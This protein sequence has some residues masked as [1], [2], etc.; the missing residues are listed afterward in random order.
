MFQQHQTLSRTV[1]INFGF[2][3]KGAIIKI[4]AISG[5]ATCDA[6]GLT[7]VVLRAHASI[8]Q[9]TGFWVF[10]LVHQGGE[11]ARVAEAMRN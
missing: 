3:Q 1:A 2:G 11:N 9:T 4:T 10:L 5:F 8:H 6:N 7:A